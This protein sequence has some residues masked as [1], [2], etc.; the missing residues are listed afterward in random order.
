MWGLFYLIQFATLCIF[1]AA[2]LRPSLLIWTMPL[3][4]FIQAIIASLSF[5][6]LPRRDTQ[7]YFADKGVM[8]YEFILET[9][10]A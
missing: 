2:S 10:A 8:S 5:T 9:E 6:S 4:G 1:E 3:T 7:G